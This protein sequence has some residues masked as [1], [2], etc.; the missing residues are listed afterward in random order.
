M[1]GLEVPAVHASAGQVT[2]VVG[3][4]GDIQDSFAKVVLQQQQRVQYDLCDMF[5]IALWAI[6]WMDRSVLPPAPS[7]EIGKVLGPPSR[8]R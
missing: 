7:D 8:P 6:S 5:M 4:H 1:G 3:I 2:V